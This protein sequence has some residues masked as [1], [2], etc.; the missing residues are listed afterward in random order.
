MLSE[1]AAGAAIP[2]VMGVGPGKTYDAVV[3]AHAPDLTGDAVTFVALEDR[4]LVVDEDV[5]EGS[6][7]PIADALEHMI[8][9]PYRA[10][11]GRTDGDAWTA[12]AES[13]R[14]VELR[15]VAG[16][17]VDLSVVDGERTLTVDGESTIRPLAALDDLAAAYD[18]VALHAERVDGDL[19]AVDVFPL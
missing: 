13:V 12:V 18:S 16:D 6:L 9:P 3:A 1:L 15:D 14:I 5:P 10:A 2:G 4:T 8:S 11:A 17:E 19:F 7:S